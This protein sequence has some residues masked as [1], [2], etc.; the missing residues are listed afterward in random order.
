[1]EEIVIGIAPQ[2]TS[3][4][5]EAWMANFFYHTDNQWFTVAPVGIKTIAAMLLT[6]A[7][8][9]WKAGIGKPQDKRD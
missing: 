7:F 6:L 2:I 9:S 3:Q 1:M 5:M 8:H 4:N